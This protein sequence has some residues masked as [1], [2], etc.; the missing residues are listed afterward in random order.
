MHNGYFN[1]IWLLNSKHNYLIIKCAGFTNFL[2]ANSPPVCI[3]LIRKPENVFLILHSVE[4][5]YKIIGGLRIKKRS[6]FR[7]SV[8]CAQ[9]VNYRYH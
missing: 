8:Y 1:I 5:G 6:L 9:F 3:F 2:T 4:C 7:Y